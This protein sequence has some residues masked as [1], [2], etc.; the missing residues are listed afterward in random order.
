MAADDAAVDW[1]AFE[2]WADRPILGP[3][4][5]RDRARAELDRF[6][7]KTIVQLRKELWQ[8]LRMKADR[9]MG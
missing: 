7:A 3:I 5:G 9:G 2:A 8:E 4:D 6:L 1:E